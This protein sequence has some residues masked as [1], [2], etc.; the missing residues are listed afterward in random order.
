MN[1]PEL[2]KRLRQAFGQ[3]RRRSEWRV[4]RLVYR[5]G[6]DTHELRFISLNRK[7]ALGEF[8]A[9]L[10]SMLFVMDFLPEGSSVL[11]FTY[12]HP[13]ILDCWTYRR[14]LRDYPDCRAQHMCQCQPGGPPHELGSD[15]CVRRMLRCS[16]SPGERVTEDSLWPTPDGPLT[17]VELRNH[18][19]IRYRCGCWSGYKETHAEADE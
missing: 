1:L 16:E 2:R 19:Y 6:V 18:G 14:A 8:G 17:G 12:R 11:K 15:Q 7:S 4:C 5:D 9:R 13:T 10:R 3:W